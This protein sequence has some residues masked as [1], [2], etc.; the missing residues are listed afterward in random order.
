LKA[1]GATGAEVAAGAGLRVYVTEHF[2]FRG[3]FRLYHPFGLDNVG[4]FYRAT[5]GIF[6]QLK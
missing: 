5:G 2:G 1:P 6:F 3:E 4:N